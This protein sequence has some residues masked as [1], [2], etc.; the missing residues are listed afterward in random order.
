MIAEYKQKDQTTKVFGFSQDAGPMTKATG[1]L[2]R[3]YHFKCWQVALKREGRGGDAV[4]G[5]GMGAIPTA[6]EVGIMTANADD[7][8]AMGITEEEAAGLSTAKLE[9]QWIEQRA[10]ASA[11]GMATDSWDAKEAWRAK[12][13]GVLKQ[14][15]DGTYYSEGHDH[16]HTKPIEDFHLRPH[17]RFAHG[18][19]YDDF[20][21]RAQLRHFHDEDHARM[22]LE[23][24][25][26]ARENDPSRVDEENRVE[27]AWPAAEPTEMEV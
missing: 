2:L 3:A 26:Q 8:K 4:S 21:P 13:K 10:L 15:E 12:E 17:L 16:K 14:R 20:T 7:L 5:R 23:K 19:E 18:L 27:R 22:A 1:Q 25:R 24:T 6:Y 11:L 9:Q